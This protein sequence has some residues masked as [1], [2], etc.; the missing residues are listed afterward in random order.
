MTTFDLVALAQEFGI[1]NIRIFAPMRPLEMIGFIPG[2]AFKSS[3]SEEKVVECE[4]DESRYKVKDNYKITLKSIDKP[5][6]GAF[7][8]KEHYY[9][10]DLNS[11]IGRDDRYSV[12]AVTIDGYTRLK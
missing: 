3:D 7:F 12:Y 11:I 8:G 9:I 6:N 4:I 2:I 10:S 5:D 1:K